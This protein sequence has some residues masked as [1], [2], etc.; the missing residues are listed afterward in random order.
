MPAIYLEDKLHD[1]SDQQHATRFDVSYQSPQHVGQRWPLLLQEFGSSQQD[2]TS[3]YL[4][5]WLNV[6]C[7]RPC[8]I[9]NCLEAV[10]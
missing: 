1:W 2:A 9:T 10:C 4:H 3:C 7:S 6:L 8:Q 5:G